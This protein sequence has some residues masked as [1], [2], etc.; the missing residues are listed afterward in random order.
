MKKFSF[1]LAIPLLLTSCAGTYESLTSSRYVGADQYEIEANRDEFG[2]GGQGRDYLYRRAFETC[3]ATGKG[4][5]IVDQQELTGSNTTVQNH[6]TTS[7]ASTSSYTKGNRMIVHC[8]GPV[9][10]K[11]AAE[12]ERRKKADE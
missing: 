5:K 6:G 1:L 2:G 8:E 7:T 3:A 10:Q 12:I 11:L 4:Y 9:D